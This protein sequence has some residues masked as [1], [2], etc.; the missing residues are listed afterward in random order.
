MAILVTGGAGF[1]GSHLVEY[2]LENTNEKIIIFDDLSSGQRENIP[3]QYAEDQIEIRKENIKNK[4]EVETAVKSADTIY[5]LAAAIGVKK[6]VNNP[7]SSFETNL[8]GTKNILD[9][10][11]KSNT[12][13]FIASSSEIYGKSIDVPFSEDDDRVLGPVQSSRWSY[14]TGK[15]ADEFI[16][17]SY[18]K[19]YNL[20]LVIGRFFNIAGPRQSGQY[21]HVIPRFVDQALSN[22]P[23]TVYGDGSQTRSFTHVHDAVEIITS[24]M[25]SSEADGEVYNIGAKN[26]ISIDELA[27]RIIELADSESKIEYIALEEVYG[28]D[29]EEPHH[30]YP[31]ISKLESTLGFSPPNDLNK[32]IKNV[33]DE[34]Q[35]KE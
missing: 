35:N 16:A 23:I 33:L 20:P 15:A 18:N 4:P 21:G 6:I 10:A 5:H 25:D 11:R 31:D 14:A 27:K 26:P 30:R 29:F 17:F 24:L 32:I 12:P 8:L 9:S 1:I 34:K 3:H 13:V 19:E 2:L 28:E 22:K 7:L